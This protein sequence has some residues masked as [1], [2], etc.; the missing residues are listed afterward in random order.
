MRM[1]EFWDVFRDVEEAKEHFVGR[2][3][4]SRS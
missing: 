1:E 3:D 4:Y 2:D